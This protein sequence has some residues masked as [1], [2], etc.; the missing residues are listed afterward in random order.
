MTTLPEQVHTSISSL[1]ERIVRRPTA[2]PVAPH[3]PPIEFHPRW[4]FVRVASFFLRMVAQIYIWD[5]F[6]GRF[7]LTRWYVRRT[8][9]GRWV[10][11]ARQFRLLAIELG[12][13]QI[14]LGQFLSS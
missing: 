1:R 8:A 13:M 4:R 11:L 6:L 9:I 2:R 12:G 3:L 10:A 14:K 7:A 5:I